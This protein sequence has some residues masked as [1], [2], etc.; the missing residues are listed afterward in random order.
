MFDMKL[1]ET[2]VWWLPGVEGWK[3]WGDVQEYKLL[4]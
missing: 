1:R 2:R 3:K 4:V